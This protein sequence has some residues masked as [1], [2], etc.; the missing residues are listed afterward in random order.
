VRLDAAMGIQFW[1][2]CWCCDGNIG[3]CVFFNVGSKS[4]TGA[5]STEEEDNCNDGV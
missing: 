5:C 2:L 1:V 3:V 4:P